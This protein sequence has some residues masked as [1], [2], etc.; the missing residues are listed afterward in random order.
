MRNMLL[1]LLLAPFTLFAQQKSFVIKGILMGM[2]DKTELVLKN[3]ES[4]PDPVASG[5]SIGENIEIKGNITEPGLYQLSAKS[6][7]QKLLIFKTIT[8]FS[9]ELF[10]M[11]YKN[12]IALIKSFIFKSNKTNNETKPDYK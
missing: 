10:G 2:P 4:G 8:A 6:G 7:Q 3:E 5:I 12:K 11:N 1:L 9:K